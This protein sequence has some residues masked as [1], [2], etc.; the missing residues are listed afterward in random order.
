MR[1]YFVL[2]I[3]IGLI[4]LL[5]ILFNMIVF[6]ITFGSKLWFKK[7]DKYL[8]KTVKINYDKDFID[9][10]NFENVYTRTFDN[11][12]MGGYFLKAKNKSNRFII[13]VHGYRGKNPSEF[14]TLEKLFYE[15]N[16]NIL[17]IDI[18]GHQNS[19]G[20][21]FTMGK[22]EQ[23]DMLYWYQYIIDN[24]KDPQIV[25]FGHSM[26]GFIVLGSLKYELPKN[27]KCVISDCSYFNLKKEIIYT[28]KYLAKVPFARL[29]AYFLNIY[30]LIFY[31]FSLNIDLKESL[32]KTN[33]PICLIHGDAD[34]FVPYGNL[35]LISELIKNS[36]K[37]EHTFKNAPHCSSESF[38]P[39]R[40]HKIVLNFV[41]RF[42]K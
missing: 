42:C 28:A 24:F 13:F 37:E 15:N 4:I 40:F 18:R 38:E 5:F 32:N 9:A 7:R 12:M 26:G 22:F 19:Q 17:A 23:K 39:E 1:L 11:K 25:V 41:N 16:Y 6:N 20:K 29:I 3:I 2:L 33:L 10:N 8:D 27:V 36:Y 31:H 35:R 21:F 34:R 30:C 14:S